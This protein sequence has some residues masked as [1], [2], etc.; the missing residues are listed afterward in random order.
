[1]RCTFY[2]NRL[3]AENSFEMSTRL[4]GLLTPCMPG[5][6]AWFCCCLFFFSK[7]TFS[8][9]SFRNAIRVTNGLDTDKGP[10]CL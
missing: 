6:F 5:N 3:L 10:N 9:N 1:M 8:N 4:I 7:S 2:V